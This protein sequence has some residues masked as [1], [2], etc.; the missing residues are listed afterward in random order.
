[1]WT[2]LLLT[3]AFIP[4]DAHDM[5]M[6]MAVV[7]SIPLCAILLIVGIVATI[8]KTKKKRAAQK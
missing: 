7:I 5:Y 4:F 1:M 2:T 8:V 3:S 6:V